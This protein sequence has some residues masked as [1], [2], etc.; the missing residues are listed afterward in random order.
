NGDYSLGGLPTRD[1]RIHFRD[2]QNGPY[3]DEWYDEQG[4]PDSAMPV[5]LAEGETRTGINAQLDPG[6]AVSG[7]VTDADG[8]PISG[9]SVNVNPVDQ[10]SNAWGQTDSDGHYTTSVLPAGSYRVQFQDSS[11]SP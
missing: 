6:I 8:N 2:C 9:I 1:L 10:G 5:V 3:A 7:T 11:P 4:N